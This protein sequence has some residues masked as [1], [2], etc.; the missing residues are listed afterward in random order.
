MF[1]NVLQ[2]IFGSKNE[3]EL[4]RL[5]PL[6]RAINELEPAVAQLSDGQLQAKTGEFR[7]RLAQG[8]TL[9]DLLTEAF[10]VVREVARRTLAQRHFDVQLVG[11]IVLHE[12]KIAE[13]KTGEGKTLAATLPLYLNA[14][15]GKGVHVVTVN[16]YL[17]KRDAAW[18]GAIYNFLGLAVGVI[19]HELD[20]LE[21]QQAYRCDITYG[22]NNEFG[23]DYLRDNM[24]FRIED[25][26]QRELNYA[27]VDE[28]DSIL[29]DEARTPLIISGAVEQLDEGYYEELKPMVIRLHQN[30][31]RL[32]QT[33]FDEA[34]RLLEE[35]PESE[36][37]I[38][39]LLLVKRGDP[40]NPRFLD[41]I[42]EKPALK[43]RLDRLESYLSGQK[44]LSQFDDKLFCAIDE[45]SNAVE[46]TEKGLELLSRGRADAFVVPSLEE[47]YL[48]IDS[49][50][51]L[52]PPERIEARQALDNQYRQTSE[53]IHTI[54]QL[55][56]AHWLFQ[57]D[58]NYVIKDG[59]VIIV[60]E[61]TGRMMPGRR[62]SDGLHQAIEA[63][64][65]VK[66]AEENQ[67]LATITFQNYFRMYKK[68]AGMTGTADTEAQEFKKI[69]KLDVMVI[70]TNMPMIRQDFSD[71]IYRTQR[72]KYKAVVEE[73]KECHRRGQPVLV[74]SISI[75]NSEKLSQM[76][77]QEKIPHQVLNA[78]YHET[79][80]KIIAQA[81]R[82]GA[83][84]ISTNMAGRGTDIMLGGNPE[85]LVREEAL[86]RKVDLST[87]P[88]GFRKILEEMR[89]LTSQEYRKVIE[90][91]G[92]HVLGTERHE[93]RRIDN[94]LRGRSGRQG[95]PGTSRFY[96]S[97]EDDLL[98]IFGSQRISG[99]MSRLGME[100]GQP[101]EHSLIS[102]AIENAQKR[103]E[104][105]NFDIRKHL[106]EY[107]DVMN[108]Q[109]EV[110]YDQ[111]KRVLAQDGV[112]EEIQELI[113]E[114]A[115]E[116]VDSIADEKTYPEEWDYRRLNE[117]LM[118][119]F[120]FGLS[121]RPEDTQNMTRE[122]LWEKVVAQAK[123]VYG[124]KG[125]E[126]GPEAM[127]HLEQV[128]YLQSIDTL[129]KEHLMAMDHLKEGI[130][131]RG[132]GQR[133]PLQEYQKEGYAMFMDLIQRIK[134][135]TI[136]KL[137]RVQIA[138]PQEVAQFEAVRKQPLILSRGEEVE[139]KQQPV[140][141][142]GKK[143]GRN[144]PCPCGSGK[145]YKKC[146]GR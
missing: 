2:K 27:I 123:E 62:W 137:F 117:S 72:E 24:K 89:A 26:V 58:V 55:V 61:F 7:E 44:I 90:A 106:L 50:D 124:G 102:R 46:L 131:L 19:V 128:I 39:Q 42:A 14:L 73:V 51:Q 5:K 115:E 37:V 104:A 4:N 57:K 60:D 28:V 18:M 78:K 92:L 80:A 64:E 66:V 111:R 136:Q 93:S 13:M 122:K 99:V 114:L 6:I 47:G 22:T 144:D 59:Q 45:R 85:M 86:R 125:A 8:E 83:L 143:V 54:H 134:E 29:I 70:P 23:F 81:G 120:S 110:I 103:V 101:I 21:R 3:R 20:D 84:T 11:G 146:H 112:A 48:T 36:T 43:T 77:K 139:E 41:L 95:D 142:E 15:T 56:K 69:Y 68:L 119:L 135:E 145:K 138:R 53:R 87:D 74:G 16:D 9:D 96:L 94:Q 129:W 127:G 25:L 63:K 141:R 49:N 126:F 12:G 98:R 91:G 97:L 35:E 40:K 109:R 82:F 1:L 108:K 105:H 71:V 79:E 67:T 133:N 132:Y 75:E 52:N 17:A 32:I 130:G 38:E 88:E 33:I 31:S 116:I 100:E 113:T 118:R 34:L 121:I 140:K 65:G 107:D 10:A 30:Q 76:L